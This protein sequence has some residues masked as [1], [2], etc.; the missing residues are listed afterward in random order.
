M[1]YKS[2]FDFTLKYY[3]T[4]DATKFS[5]TVQSG[6]EKISDGVYTSRRDNGKGRG[7]KAKLSEVWVGRKLRSNPGQLGIKG[8]GRE[9]ED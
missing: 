8:E 9:I 7:D 5:K 3:Y 2:V 4:N 1:F 6:N